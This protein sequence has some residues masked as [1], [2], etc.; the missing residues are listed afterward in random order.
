MRV[1][2]SISALLDAFQG[3]HAVRVSVLVVGSCIRYPESISQNN[4]TATVRTLTA[5]LRSLPPMILRNLPQNV[6][7][8]KR[9]LVRTRVRI[10][11]ETPIE[12]VEF[13]NPNSREVIVLSYGISLPEYQL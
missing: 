12:M 13:L 11:R 3:L 10:D 6:R 2:F 7:E 9:L 4:P 5:H 1:R 8:L